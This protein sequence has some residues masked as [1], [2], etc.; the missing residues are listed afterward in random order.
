[1][2][3]AFLAVTFVIIREKMTT[4]VSDAGAAPLQDVNIALPPTD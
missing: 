2:L 3:I 1:M 4:P